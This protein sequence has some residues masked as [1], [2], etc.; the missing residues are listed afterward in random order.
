MAKEEGVDCK[1]EIKYQTVIIEY[2][3]PYRKGYSGKV[4]FSKE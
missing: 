1:V 2:N 4:E 3:F